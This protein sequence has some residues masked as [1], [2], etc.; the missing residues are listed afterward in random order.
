M[1]FSYVFLGDQHSDIPASVSHWI[2]T[3]GHNSFKVHQVSAAWAGT[4]F[5]PSS[6]EMLGSVPEAPS[7]VLQHP[8]ACPA[9]LWAYLATHGGWS[10]F[11]TFSCEQM[12]INGSD[13]KQKGLKFHMRDQEGTKRAQRINTV[14]L[15]ICVSL[16]VFQWGRQCDMS[17]DPENGCQDR[18]VKQGPGDPSA[19]DSC[20]ILVWTRGERAEAGW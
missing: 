15:C 18:A 17:S 5:G 3:T 9:G 20:Y 6:C 13:F 10:P 7:A 16:C 2:H 14:I 12:S 4:L 11:T 19:P 8:Q 1:C